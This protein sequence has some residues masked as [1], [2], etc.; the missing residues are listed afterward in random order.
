MTVT[1]TARVLLSTTIL[2]SLL[3]TA[4]RADPAP[5]PSP[6]PAPDSATLLQT[7]MLVTATR[8]PQP[9]ERIGSSV[10]SIDS[11][12]IERR[13]YQ[14]VYQALESL[15]GVSLSRSGPFGGTATLRIRGARSEQTLVLVDGV[16]V[17]DPSSP[18][19]GFDFSIMDP[20]DIERIE[21]LRGP[22]STLYGSDAIGGVVNI[23]TK[24]GSDGI[25]VNGF[26][27][28]GSF[29]TLRG[30]ATISGAAGGFDYRLS[31]S[32]ITTDGIS[33]ADRRDGNTER[34]GYD[35][36]QLSANVGYQ[37]T[38][39]FRLEGFARHANSTT[40]YDGYGFATGT[41][42][43]PDKSDITDWA[44]S[45]R[46]L[47]T[48]M[49]GRFENVIAINHSDIER[50]NYGG[51][52]DFGSSGKRTAVSYQGNYR[53]AEGTILTVGAENEQT[54]IVTDSDKADIT[55]DS[56][57]AQAQVLLAD[58]LT[59]TGG[60]RYDHH[61]TF[62]GKTTFRTTAAYDLAATGTVLRASWGQG[63]KAPTAYQLTFF[64]CGAAG[65]NLDLKPEESE[66]WDAGI[67]QRIWGDR[68]TASLNYFRQSTNNLIDYLYPDGYVNI[69]RTRSRGIEA[70]VKIVPVD[71]FALDANYTHTKAIDRT[72]GLA[73]VRVP[74]DVANVTATVRP[75]D[76]LSLSLGVR[77]TGAEQDV[78]A[79]LDDWVRVDL[80]ASWSLTDKIDLFA[81][82]ENLFD[83]KY[84]E[85]YGYGTPGLSAY[86]GVRG[87]F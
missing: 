57:Y 59:L 30:G 48:L 58:A 15:P 71:W 55:I 3:A 26:A 36:V 62:G 16:E 2:G 84:Q 5:A 34:D 12:E 60:V 78:R 21:I 25:H 42:D 28:G 49:D 33:K 11:V 47:V 27:E 43:S 66:G 17:N 8:T 65:P 6:A 63:F 50:K 85:V 75:V 40:A 87:R 4:V 67:E 32:A 82:I 79:R 73:L 13:Q 23:I 52:F 19:G 29:N 20:N 24:R 10:S 44:F 68:I 7:S 77:Y 76:R 53:I 18:S 69:A 51:A 54:A 45:G 61:E 1:M 83:A 56:L 80:R 22:Q 39:E 9:P 74:K 35:D 14:F 70:G 72:T 64:C 81:R 37:V 41:E 86:A 31:A 38:D 46:A